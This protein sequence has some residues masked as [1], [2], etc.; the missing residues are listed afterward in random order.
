MALTD[1]AVKYF[2]INIIKFNTDFFLSF[3]KLY[4]EK[5]GNHQI[6]DIIAV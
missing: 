6:W 2:L 5:A 4:P 3:I 1:A